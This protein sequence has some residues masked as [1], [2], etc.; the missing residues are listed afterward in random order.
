MER[1]VP[2]DA[3]IATLLASCS[4]AGDVNAFL[5]ER[6][7]EEQLH[8]ET[9]AVNDLADAPPSVWAE[10]EVMIAEPRWRRQGLAREALQ[11]LL[12]FLTADPT[13]C[14]SSD[15]PH[16]STALPIAKSRLFARISMYNAPSIAL[17]EQLGFIRGKE[18]TVFE[19]VELRVTDESLIQCTKPLA[20][21]EW[22]EPGAV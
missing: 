3:N 18:Y 21:L 11:M 10:L 6:Y 2:K 12:Y 17:F 15:T 19:E 5:S 4:M 1:P 7:D 8:D 22:P 9:D 14:A 16:R 13:P 20:V